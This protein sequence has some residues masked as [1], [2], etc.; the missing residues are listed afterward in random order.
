MV[1]MATAKE[2]PIFSISLQT[3]NLFPVIAIN[4]TRVLSQIKIKS[5]ISKVLIKFSRLCF[6]IKKTVARANAKNVEFIS[7]KRW[8]S[9]CDIVPRIVAEH[10]KIH[11]IVIAIS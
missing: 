11:N 3:M 10:I 7:M 2:G 6:M 8:Y 4:P 5:T 9:I 1:S